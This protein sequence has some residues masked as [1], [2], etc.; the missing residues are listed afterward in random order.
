MASVS[1]SR[2]SASFSTSVAAPLARCWST[3]SA[4]A[5]RQVVVERDRP[6]LDE[7]VARW[8]PMNPAA[9][10]DEGAH[11]AGHSRCARG[12]QTL[13]TLHLRARWRHDGRAAVAKGHFAAGGRKARYWALLVPLFGSGRARRALFTS[14]AVRQRRKSG[15]PSAAGRVLV[16]A[17]RRRGRGAV[18]GGADGALEFRRRA[19][20][21]TRRGA[22]RCHP[23]SEALEVSILGSRAPELAGWKVAREAEA[24][25][26][27]ASRLA[28]PAP[29]A[30][31]YDFT[32]HVDPRSLTCAS[33]RRRAARSTA[34]STPVLRSKAAGSGA[35]DLPAA[36]FACPGEPTHVFVGRDDHR[37][38]ADAPAA[39]HLVAPARR[40]RRD[41]DAR[42]AS[43][44]LG[45]KI[46]GHVGHGLA[47]RARPRRSAVHGSSVVV[48]GDRGGQRS[49]TTSGDFWKAFELP[50]GSARAGTR[51][52][53]VSR[54]RARRGTH[55]CFEADSR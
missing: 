32:D 33:R 50:L 16:Q 21:R 13:P 29:P 24:G 11:A 55:V 40:R 28:N 46:H 19:H 31:T 54:E 42:F 39:L 6:V 15:P 51:R 4:L 8:L 52:R 20:A 53:R 41:G 17:G 9:A 3:N 18:L 1:A 38:R 2:S 37:G 47:H 35:A 49:S 25:K 45:T 26:V 12:G 14:R 48:G 22:A 34:P 7:L 43:V 23:L 10:D 30:V 36:R 5:H 44:P 27:H